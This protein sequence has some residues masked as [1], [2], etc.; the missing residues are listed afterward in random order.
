MCSE[1]GFHVPQPEVRPNETNP[2]GFGEPR[3]VVDFHASLMRRAKVSLFDGRP[4]A[5]QRAARVAEKQRFQSTLDGWLRNEFDARDLLVVKDPR[6]AWFLTMWQT[7]A[8]RIGARPGFITP[9][10]HPTEVLASVRTTAGKRQPEASRA[11][12]WISMVLGSER[13]TR[14]KDRAYLLFDDLLGDWRSELQRAEDLTGLPL[15]GRASPETLRRV[16]NF[17]DPGLRR[18][19][20]GWDH[21]DVPNSI[22]NL[23]EEVWDALTTLA[24]N[25]VSEAACL[26][27]LDELRQDYERLYR[28]SEAIASESI[29]AAATAAAAKTERPAGRSN[30]LP[31]EKSRARRLLRRIRATK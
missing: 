18:S 15:I 24:R 16:N 10:R 30:P 28:D 21:V 1:L 7:S 6:T 13:D 22:R 9:L 5:W 11:A 19:A 2:K 27:R 12:W 29:R 17:V 26:P 4:V 3:W 23:A 20:R 14:G 8:A 31:T 25:P